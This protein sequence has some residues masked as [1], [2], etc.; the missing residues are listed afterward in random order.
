MGRSDT[1]IS[2]RLRQLT[3]F[4]AGIC[5]LLDKGSAGGCG[6]TPLTASPGV[7]VGVGGAHDD[8]GSM[9]LDFFNL[10]GCETC[11]T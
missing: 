1:D 11:H 7:G 3:L 10:V 6:G 4:V 2:Y 9:S 5:K 8:F